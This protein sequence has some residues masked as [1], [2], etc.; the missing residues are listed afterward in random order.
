MFE[1]ELWELTINEE[2]N[3]YEIIDGKDVVIYTTKYSERKHQSLQRI[4]AMHNKAIIHS[5]S[6]VTKNQ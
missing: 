2:E 4:V 5:L 1:D 3:I 6:I